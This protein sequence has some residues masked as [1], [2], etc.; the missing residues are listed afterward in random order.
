[1]PHAARPGGESLRRQQQQQLSSA[2]GGGRRC[3]ESL[4]AAVPKCLQ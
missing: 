1:M 3:P 2:F 4:R